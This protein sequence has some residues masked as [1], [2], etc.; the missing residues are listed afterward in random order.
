MT[1]DQF[2]AA[3]APPRRFNPSAPSIIAARRH[4]V[5]GVPMSVAGREVGISRQGVYDAVCKIRQGLCEALGYPRGHVA[6]TVVLPANSE[7]INK[8]LDIE[9]LSRR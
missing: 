4:L 8:V 6:V 3:I 9:A 5:D 2:N 7:F 1:N